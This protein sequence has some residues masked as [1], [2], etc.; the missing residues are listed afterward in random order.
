MTYFIERYYGS[1]SFKSVLEPVVSINFD[2]R[3][4]L[5]IL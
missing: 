3:L 4:S 1:L 5:Q 2:D